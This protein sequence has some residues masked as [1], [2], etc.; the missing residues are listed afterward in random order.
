MN[1][2]YPSSYKKTLE[3]LRKKAIRPCGSLRVSVAGS[4]EPVPYAEKDRLNEWLS[5]DRGHFDL[6]K[7]PHH[8]SW[9]KPLK[10]LLEMTQPAY[11]VITSSDAEPE[12]EETVDLLETQHVETFFTRRGAVRFTCDG[13]TLSGEYL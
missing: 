9:H 13:H 1:N 7:M 3:A 11:A 6:V 2:G 5:V 12:D 10:A 8:G 4:R